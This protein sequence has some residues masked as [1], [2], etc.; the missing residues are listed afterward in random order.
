MTSGDALALT[1]R[2]VTSLA[3]DNDRRLALGLFL[4][5][6]ARGERVAQRS[7]DWQMS[8]A[9]DPRAIRFFRAQARQEAMHARLFDTFATWLDAPRLALT[10]C[11]YDTWEARIDLAAGAGNYLETIVATQV[12]LEAL[13]EALLARLDAGL[14]RA[15]AGFKRLRR[16][17]RAQEA[18]HHAFGTRTIAAAL[19]AEEIDEAALRAWSLPYLALAQ[20]MITAGAPA[21]THF[22]LTAET[23]VVEFRVHLPSWVGEAA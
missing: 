4:R 21:L 15:G 10:Q 18:A 17:L 20:A 12:V 14:D 5:H 23:I 6:L 8:L 22:A 11:P 3:L 9:R 13:G 1:R 2:A 19:A 16:L 7:A